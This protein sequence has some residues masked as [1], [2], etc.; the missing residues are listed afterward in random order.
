M[1]RATYVPMVLPVG[2]ITWLAGGGPGVVCALVGAVAGVTFLVPP[3][4]SPVP[5]DSRDA[6][7]TVLYLLVA[8]AVVWLTD[9]AKRQRDAIASERERIQRL[10]DTNTEMLALRDGFS[11]M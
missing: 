7:G 4:G 1:D 5:A 9:I 11:G 2:I 6:L 10:L 3:I 8:L